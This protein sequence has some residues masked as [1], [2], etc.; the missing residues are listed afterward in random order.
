M[1]KFLKLKDAA[2]II[3]G[4]PFKGEQYSEI[5]TRT[6]RG[7]NVTEGALRWDTIKCWNQHFEKEAYYLLEM[8]DIVIGMDGSKVGKNKARIKAADLPLLLAQRVACVRAKENNDQIFLYYL[9]HNPRFEEYVFKTQT[10]SSVPHISKAQIENYDVPNIDFRNQRQIASILSALDDK[11]ELNNKINAELEQMAKTLYDYW[12]VQFDFP[13]AQGKPD[14]DEKPYK[15]SGGKM[16]YNEVLKREIPEGWN[17]G[18]L[19]GIADLQGGG[20]PNTSNQVF[21]NGDIPFFTPSDAN[22]SVFSIQTIQ[23]ITKSGLERSSTKLFEKGTIF[24]TARGSVGRVMIASKEMAMNQSCYALKPKDKNY[25]F[26]Y[27][28]TLGAVGYLRAKSSGSIFN[29][30]VSN[31][32][33]FTP[34]VIPAA[35][36]RNRFN[37]LMLPLFERILINLQQNQQLSTLRDWL[38]PM[39]MNGQ[40]R[41]EEANKPSRK[42]VKPEDWIASIDKPLSNN[43]LLTNSEKYVRRKMLASFII[44]SSLDDRYFGKTKFEKLLHL[45]EYHIVKGDYGQKYTVQAAGP[46]DGSFTKR[47]WSEV[48]RGGWYRL[49]DFGSL[50]RV[51]AGDSHKSS[52]ADYGYLDEDIKLKIS[53]FISIFKESNFERPEIISTLYAVWNNRII[54]HELINDALLKKDFL[55]WDAQKIKYEDRIDKALSW[56][57]ENGIVPTGWGTII[58]KKTQKYG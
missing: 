15:S 22:N 46:Y 1:S 49:E 42:I 54:K 5:G 16:V 11:I 28:S 3:T 41:I 24:L 53:G 55:E 9:I 57:K 37:E 36:V 50:Q 38:L 7:E 13:F 14:A 31:D 40:I 39:L 43:P 19:L 17:V 27:F 47:F 26:L 34:V 25:T 18:N 29:A 20:T 33:K 52:L 32:I 12:F 6:V 4:Y 58:V 45:I 35:E 2:E 10:G 51:M 44:N 30:I 21:W 23:N 56:M 48:L 8:N